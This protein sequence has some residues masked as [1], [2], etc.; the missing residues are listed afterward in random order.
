[1]R[2]FDYLRAQTEGEA[3]AAAARDGGAFI[4]G[5]TDLMPLWKAGVAAPGRMID[6]GRLPLAEVTAGDGGL[7]LGATARLAD[8]ADHLEV[9]RRHPAVAQAIEASASGQVR[10]MATVGGA[11]LQRTRCAYFRSGITP[12]EKLEPGS[13]CAAVAGENRLHAIFGGGPSCVATHASD[14]AVALVALDAQVRLRSLAGERVLPLEAL[15]LPAGESPTRET[16]LEQGEMIAVVD[17]PDAPGRSLYLKVRDRASFEF[18]V[19]SVAVALEVTNGRIVRARIAAG[20]VGTIPWRLSASEAALTGAEVG[21]A[22]YRNAAALAADGA[23]PLTHNGF[24][25][26]LLKRTVFRALVQAGDQA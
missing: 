15:Y 11:L 10:N 9:R 18:A 20:G 13:G 7:M 5:G 26:E 22:A 2:A 16:V 1:M 4:A 25:I 17:V 23:Q 21:E 8:I 6:I 14:L 3:L 19:V 24:K 12:C